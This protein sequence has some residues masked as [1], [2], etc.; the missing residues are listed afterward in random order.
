MQRNWKGR[1][2]DLELLTTRI[3]DFFKAKDFEAIRGEIPTGYKIFAEGSPYFKIDGYV[4]VAIE[5]N[6]NDFVVKFD[7][8]KKSKRR[9][10]MSGILSETMFLGGYLLSRKLKSEEEW[11]RLE[12]EFWRHVDNVLLFLGNSS[13]SPQVDE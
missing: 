1:N 12:K 13:K 7:L 11:L 3:G 6:P 9:F 5:G 8:C 10:V 4:S 2:I